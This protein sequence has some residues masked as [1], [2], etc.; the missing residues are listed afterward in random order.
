M[1]QQH[2]ALRVSQGLWRAVDRAIATGSHE[3]TAFIDVNEKNTLSH[4]LDYDLKQVARHLDLRLESSGPVTVASLPDVYLGRLIDALPV[5][6][7][8][9]ASSSD[10]GTIWALGVNLAKVYSDVAGTLDARCRRDQ[11]LRRFRRGMSIC[12]E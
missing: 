6:P 10:L 5:C 2:T 8:A 12:F 9:S 3:A 11:L 7:Q 1:A 4:L